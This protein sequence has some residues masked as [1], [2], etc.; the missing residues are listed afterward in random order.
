MAVREAPLLLA[1]NN[2]SGF[3]IRKDFVVVLMGPGFPRIPIREGSGLGSQES[4]GFELRNGGADRSFDRSCR[5]R[6]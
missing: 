5:S 2:S 3:D 1:E 6:R 4:R